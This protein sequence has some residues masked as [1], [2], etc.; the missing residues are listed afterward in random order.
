MRAAQVVLLVVFLTTVAAARELMATDFSCSGVYEGGFCWLEDVRLYATA[1]WRFSGVPRGA[2]LTLRLEGMAEDPCEDCVGRDV[3]LRIFYGPG[4][5]SWDRMDLLL[6]HRGPE[7]NPGWYTVSG[8]MEFLWLPVTIA[9]ELV[10]IVQRVILCD[11]HVGFNLRSLVLEVP[12]EG[13]PEPSP[14]PPPPPREGCVVPSVD[15]C[16]VDFQGS[17]CPVPELPPTDIPRQELPET[18]GPGEAVLIPSGDYVGQLGGPLGRSGTDHHDWYRL[19]TGR[20]E[21]LVVW[22]AADPGLQFDVYFLDIC[23]N[24]QF[25]YQGGQG[26]LQCIA[27]CTG[28]GEACDWYIR[29]VRRS[30]QGSY[31]LS[32]YPAIPE[33]SP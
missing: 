16:F 4:D 13:P 5:G 26:V 29:I 3:L 7:C 2:Y 28:A 22:I 15:G 21:A 31:Y 18:N 11:P 6:R 8:E 33:G 19:R 20:G 9:S 17:G 12:E 1:T 30:G 25:R 32:L 27:P 23:G 24:E 10:V 14:T